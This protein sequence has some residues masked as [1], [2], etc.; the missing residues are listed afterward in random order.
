MVTFA[1]LKRTQGSLEKIQQETQALQK[2]SF[3]KDERYW[4]LQTDKSGDG[5][6]VIRFLP[7]PAKSVERLWSYGFKHGNQWYIE[8]SPSTLGLPDPL[9]EMNSDLYN[10]GDEGLKKIAQS[11]KRKL[12]Y[13]A[14]IYVVKH[15]ARPEDEGKVFLFKFGQKINDKLDAKMTPK[16]E[17][18][19]PMNPFDMFTGANFR[20]RQKKV[21][22]FPNYDDSE[23][24]YPAPLDKDE[25]KMEAIFNKTY[26]V[27][28]E[29]APNQFKSYNELKDRMEK[30]GIIAPS[31]SGVVEER[32][33]VVHDT[34]R[35]DA[36]DSPFRSVPDDVVAATGSTLADADSM[37]WFDQLGK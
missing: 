15:K 24:D 11:R 31:K 28:A 36:E 19:A 26:P 12:S 1:D 27:E 3:A 16:E 6:A 5:S 37:D 9:M 18:Q 32:R 13:I 21:A 7:G 20:L 23:F 25:S 30:V 2:K 17:D 35:V 22:D 8:N 4:R 10:S 34:R 14:N 29:V 33:E